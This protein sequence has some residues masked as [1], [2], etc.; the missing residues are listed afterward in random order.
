MLILAAIGLALG[1]VTVAAAAAYFHIWIDA[2]YAIVACW[3]LVPLA[4]LV[5]RAHVAK[6][7]H[8]HVGVVA[9][10]HPHSYICVCAANR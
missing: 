8:A 3:L 7:P 2:I 10:P 4:L 5:Q 1:V 9:T 6:P